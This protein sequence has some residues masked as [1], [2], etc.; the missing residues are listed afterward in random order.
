MWSRSIF[1][2]VLAIFMASCRQDMQDQPRYKPLA[3]TDFFG[4]GRSARPLVADTVA[5]GQLRID[6]ALYTGKIGDTDVD[7]F[8]FPI[9]RADLQ[10]GQERFNIYCSPCHDYVGNANGFIVQRGFPLP[11]SYHIQRLREAP[12]GHFYGVI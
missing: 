10:R 1:P 6:D 4:D 9:T 8:P 11:A 12:A 5:R 3:A 2:A 7:T